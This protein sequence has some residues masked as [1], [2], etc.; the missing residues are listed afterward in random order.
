MYI[1]GKRETTEQPSLFLT[2]I[3]NV[4]IPVV[5]VLSIYI[6]WTPAFLHVMYLW[7]VLQII[8]IFYHIV[9]LNW[10]F[11]GETQEE[12]L[13][14]SDS[15]QKFNDIKDH[16]NTLILQT[17]DTCPKTPCEESEDQMAQPLSLSGFGEHNIPAGNH[18]TH[19]Q[20]NKITNGEVSSMVQTYPSHETPIYFKRDIQTTVIT[21]E[22]TL[23]EKKY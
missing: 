15:A 16:N 20:T 17:N 2:G 4:I 21:F 10:Y 5:N 19:N 1:N 23:I 9:L 22:N 8:D 12:I 6:Y 3:A 7:V 13:Y 14:E 18:L 11:N